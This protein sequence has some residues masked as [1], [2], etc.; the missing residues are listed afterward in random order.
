MMSA[1]K[2]SKQNS[3]DLG[4]ALE[5][6]T[7]DAVTFDEFKDLML[8]AAEQSPDAPAYVY[9]VVGLD[10]KFDLLPNSRRVI[11][12]EP[13]WAS[14]R[15]ES[16]A[17]DGIAYMRFPDNQSDLTSKDAA[18]K[19]LQDNPQILRKFKELFPDVEI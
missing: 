1:F 9:D 10:G 5:C 7:A 17:I 14:T 3:T 16:K 8:R 19:A 2:I 6:L 11:G 15:A 4:F 13:D 12:F 18:V